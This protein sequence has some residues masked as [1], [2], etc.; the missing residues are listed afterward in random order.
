MS[1]LTPSHIG[2]LWS[3]LGDGL[4]QVKNFLQLNCTDVGLARASVHDGTAVPRVSRHKW[5]TQRARDGPAQYLEFIQTTHSQTVC[6][7]AEN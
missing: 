7:S 5:S 6:I 3:I 1:W 4:S 2:L